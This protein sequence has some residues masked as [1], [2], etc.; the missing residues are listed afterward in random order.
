MHLA[1]EILNRIES[2]SD[3]DALWLC[4]TKIISDLGFSCLSYV[5]VRRLPLR[6]ESL[7]FYQTSARQDFVKAYISMGLLGYDPVVT[8]AASSNASFTWADCHEF[9]LTG[10]RRTG[11]KSRARQV[12]DLARDHGYT[13]GF[14]IPLH[15]VDHNGHPASALLSLYWADDPAAM[16]HAIPF[17][18]KLAGAT[19]HEKLL[20]FRGV[21]NALLHA[22]PRLTDR[23]REVLVWACR[24]KT[25]SETADILNIAE[26]TVEYHF[27]NAMRK[28]GVHNKYHAIAVAVQ[29]RLIA[30]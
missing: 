7:P 14:V 6:G 13:Q 9:G 15:A 10:Q 17:W 8:R 25:R 30:P 1:E 29:S 27:E 2:A 24:G 22:P 20:E 21:A 18:L 5:D 16:E 28:L 11:P 26:R 19:Y 12:M 4:M 3:K 23:E